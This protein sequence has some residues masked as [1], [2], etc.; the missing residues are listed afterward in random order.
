MQSRV[1]SLRQIEFMLDGVLFRW[2]F[3]KDGGEANFA[4]VAVPEHIGVGFFRQ[5]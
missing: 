3:E 2:R 5:G 1:T 4:R